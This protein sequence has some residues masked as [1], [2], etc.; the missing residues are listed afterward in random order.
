MADAIVSFAT[1]SL[2]NLL[3]EQYDLLSGEK[4]KEYE[5][6]LKNEMPLIKALQK[7]A[8]RSRSADER[9]R[10]FARNIIDLIY[11]IEDAMEYITIKMEYPG[12]T[13][14][15]KW[16]Q[17]ASAKEVEAEMEEIS[18][19]VEF[20]SRIAQVIGIT[21]AAGESSS[22]RSTKL[23][24]QTNGHDHFVGRVEE[25]EL[26]RSYIKDP[27]CR[28]IAIWGM[29]G[30][31]KTALAKKLY[32]D[33]QDKNHFYAVACVYVSQDFEP[34]RVFEDLY[35][36]FYPFHREDV[37]AIRGEELAR[38]VCEIQQ[39]RKCLVVLDDIWSP[40]VWE[41][42][43][44]AFPS[45]DT[46]SK[47]LI[48]TRVRQ[49]AEAVEIVAE[50]RYIHRLRYF[51]EDE[52][53]QLFRE[54][55]LLMDL[56]ESEADKILEMG[57]KV[58]KFCEGLPSPVVNFL[59]FVATKHHLEDLKV[60]HQ[61][62]ESYVR[63]SQE[64]WGA[65]STL[66]HLSL[67]Y[68]DLPDFLKPCFLY[69]GNFGEH[70][71]IDAEKLYLFWV[72]EGLISLK[73]CGVG[74]RL[75]DVAERYLN[76]LAQRSIVDVHEEELPTV[77]RFKS[78]RLNP[79]MRN[80]SL[81]KSKEQGFFKVEDFG[82]GHNRPMHD[83][84]SQNQV[85]RLAIDFDKYED[86]YD[87][88][89][90]DNEKKHIRCLLFS[91]KENRPRFGW[92]KKL[93]SLIGFKYLR[94]L[95]FDGFDFQVI[96]PP[97]DIGKLFL[98][99]YL[100]FRNCVLPKLPSSVGNLMQL[101]ILDLRVRPLSKI[102]IP[103]ILWKLKK[104]MH[105][106]FPDSFHTRDARKLRLEGLTK[107]ETIINFNTGMLNFEDLS[108]LTNLRYISS[109][110]AGSSE[111]IVCIT[112]CMKDDDLLST[113]LEIRN[114][115]CYAEEKHSVFRNV[116][117]CQALTV[118]FME[119]HIF[120]LPV[121]DRISGSLAKLVLVGSQLGED[122]MK[123]LQHLPKLRELIL[124]DDAFVEKEMVCSAAGFIELERLEIWNLHKLGKWTVQDQAMPKLSTLAIVNCRKLE[125][126]P[127]GLQ[128]VR[129]L[130]QMNVWEVHEELE[131]SLKKVEEQMRMENVQP[132]PK[133]LFKHPCS[134][135]E[136]T[137]DSKS[138]P[139]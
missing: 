61:N 72:A 120:R 135:D 50:K 121:H 6:Y 64:S 22:N 119:G 13:F 52:S 44:I 132:L 82:H 31:G 105:L 54:R 123:T 39:D 93:S 117:E 24:R 67:S 51:T 122:P 137:R 75:K 86:G 32:Q 38:R 9:I 79:L 69:L 45:G 49:A 73:D 18:N 21:Q 46:A 8:E 7:D 89:L 34:R 138:G 74:E 102:T 78:C 30:S 43:R 110:I 35:L 97:Q 62:L 41:T 101:L 115:D 27:K 70:A 60:V 103:N 114:F 53:C 17:M 36:Q 40:D 11:R 3:M 68:D 92:P 104:L 20:L 28:V 116:L 71:Q 66:Q 25:M 95:Y 125:M 56:P 55:V 108:Q 127:E 57:N 83:S 10:L 136:R 96:K 59:Q 134:D 94:I 107:L 118:L 84:L 19:R 91:A 15:R 109:K 129:R 77:T 65:G 113:S 58:V 133:I 130:Q 128:F 112:R 80:L 111:E 81:F 2:K 85:Y 4:I 98:L 23:S 14:F 12:A 100:S 48:T 42:L 1:S 131:K 26:L 47:V 5:E 76:D 37:S 63:K 33:F 87:F 16:V 29:G 139:S 99:K 106:Y 126:P 88:P 90:E 124:N